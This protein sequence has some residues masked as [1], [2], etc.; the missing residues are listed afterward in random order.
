MVE[1]DVFAVVAILLSGER[2]ALATFSS[3]DEARAKIAGLT[4]VLHAV[5]V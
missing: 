2:I 3:E 5:R 1:H 4:T